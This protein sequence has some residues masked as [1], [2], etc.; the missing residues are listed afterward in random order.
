MNLNEILFE[1]PIDFDI[2]SIKNTLHVECSQFLTESEGNP[3]FKNLQISYNNF[4]KVKIRLKKRVDTI[5][6]VFNE[7][8]KNETHHLSQRAI[9][10]SGVKNVEETETTE[11]F[12]IFPVNGYRFLYSKEVTSSSDQYKHVFESLL[13]TLHDNQT[14]LELVS[15]ILKFSYESK[16]LVEGINS[17]AEIIIYNI[18]YYYAVRSSLVD[19]YEDLLTAIS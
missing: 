8:F 19:S 5:T 3:L 16:N 15:D 18:P 2:T 6:E 9:F 17:E 12:F 1:Q 11:P 10:S 7:T 14:A 4:Q 13:S